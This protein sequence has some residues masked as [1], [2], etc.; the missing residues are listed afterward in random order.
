MPTSV[1]L[2]M[3]DGSGVTSAIFRFYVAPG[4]MIRGLMTAN[5]SPGGVS[6]GFFW[7]A[8][9]SGIIFLLGCSGD[10]HSLDLIQHQSHVFWSFVDVGVN[11]R[12]GHHSVLLRCSE[13]I[14]VF[15]AGL[16]DVVCNV[17]ASNQI[18][19]PSLA[20]LLSFGTCFLL[21]PSD[22]GLLVFLCG[23]TDNEDFEEKLKLKFGSRCSY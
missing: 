7:S 19:L 5:Q 22:A 9:S 8:R 15:Y 1:F 20:F 4:S 11:Q 2:V 14:T 16:D 18:V 10:D 3:L 6:I 23:A 17:T 13:N 21:L 12:D